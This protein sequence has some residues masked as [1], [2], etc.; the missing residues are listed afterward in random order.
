MSKAKMLKVGDRVR[1]SKYSEY[2]ICGSISNPIDVTGTVSE[3]DED[4]N[5]CYSV[6]WDNGTKNGYGEG[7]LYLYSEDI[8]KTDEPTVLTVSKEF[9]LEAHKAA[10]SDWKKKLEEQFPDVFESNKYLTLVDLKEGEGLVS[11]ALYV[12]V[13]DV[14]REYRY[15]ALHGVNLVDGLANGKDLPKGARYK[16]LYISK[17]L[18]QYGKHEMMHKYLG[19]GAHVVYFEKK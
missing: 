16:A 15:V 1:I 11:P 10:C 17:E 18:L 5:L 7:D 12:K 2:Y 8:N 6:K 19:G 3:V 14:N 13:R 4:E 9:V